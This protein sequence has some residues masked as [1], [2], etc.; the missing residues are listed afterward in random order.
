MLKWNH[1]VEDSLNWMQRKW[2]NNT[3]ASTI[4]QLSFDIICSFLSLV[5]SRLV[6][7]SSSLLSARLVLVCLFTS[8]SSRSCTSSYHCM[9]RQLSSASLLSVF[10][11]AV[12]WSLL[13]AVPLYATAPTCDGTQN[14][15]TIGSFCSSDDSTCHAI[16]VSNAAGVVDGAP[17]T[18]TAALNPD[19]TFTPVDGGANSFIEADPWCTQA[20]QQSVG[21]QAPSLR[22]VDG[23]AVTMVQLVYQSVSYDYYYCAGCSGYGS[24]QG[25]GTA[26]DDLCPVGY[27]CQQKQT[28]LQ[29]T[30][31]YGVCAPNTISPVTCDASSAAHPVPKCTSIPTDYL[32]EDADYRCISG[33]CVMTS[34]SAAR[35][36]TPSTLYDTVVTTS[37]TETYSPSSSETRYYCGSTGIVGDPQLIG[38]RG[39]SFQVHGIDQQIYNVITH[40]THQVNTRFGFLSKGACPPV[41][42][43]GAV[44]FHQ[45]CWSHPGSYIIEAGL[46]QRIA[47]ET[48]Q[49][50]IVA[51]SAQQGFSSV[52]LNGRAL[53]VPSVETFSA[54]NVN[55]VSI[56]YSRS[57][58]IVINSPLFRYEFD[59][60][61]MFLNQGTMANKQLNMLRTHGLLGQTWSAKSNGTEIPYVEGLVDDYLVTDGI[62][63][64][65]FVY[66][67]FWSNIA[68]TTFTNTA[69]TVC[70]V[71]RCKDISLKRCCNSEHPGIFYF[72]CW[73]DLF[74]IVCSFIN[75]VVMQLYAVTWNK[76]K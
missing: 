15:C 30:G 46:Q 5:S 43:V 71:V 64:K 62:F 17:C 35:C 53:S 65:E 66:N 56:D 38:L 4:D 3:N 8:R 37:Y 72:I 19:S 54:D 44:K 76:S 39:Q 57:H 16:T 32:R 52:T 6:L 58:S 10:F 70:I 9:I 68:Y 34:N 25:T 48:I 61:D 40:T 55:V 51:G 14:F 23:Q 11:V 45:N 1:L 41:E 22:C 75:E 21:S 27:Y 24:N 36:L 2:A 12:A 13:F 29:S 20:I 7:C 50:R 60:S 49:L 42:I 69:H 47:N 63:G 33:N 73:F 26:E 31:H 28:A 59:N 67:L 74:V 18:P